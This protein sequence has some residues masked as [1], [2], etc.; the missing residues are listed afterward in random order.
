[1]A[2]VLGLDIGANSIGWALLDESENAGAV[3]AMG[4]RVFPEG[5]AR[6]KSG[7]EI[8]KNEQRRIARGIR[9]QIARRARRKRVLR[10][11]LV[12]AGLYPQHLDEQVT[13]GGLDPYIL[14]EKAVSERLTPHELGRVLIHLN[15]RRGFL[16]NRK[17]DRGKNAKESSETLQQ[18][19]ALAIAIGENTLG[20]HLA[21]IRSHNQHD[22]LRERRTAREMFVREFDRIWEFQT[23]FH[24][25]LLTEELKYGATGKLD[26]PRKPKDL[27]HRKTN[28]L[29]QFVGLHGI[30]FFQR[31]IY[32]PKS[33][34]GIC[35]LEKKEKRC[36]KADRRIQKLRLLQDVN[37]LRIQDARGKERKL[38]SGQRAALVEYLSINGEL[39]FEDL[40]KPLKAVTKTTK[41]PTKIT[42]EGLKHVLALE[43]GDLFNLE[44]GKKPKL[45]GMITDVRLAHKNLFGA[46][47]FERPED[48]KNRIVRSIIDD[49]EHD[50]RHKAL[51]SWGCDAALVEK[52]VK[53]DLG[54]GR[55][56][57]SLVA[58]E[59]L[60]PHLEK[61]L[62]LM[63]NDASDSAL[64]AANYLRD[65]QKVINQ[66][67]NLPAPPDDIRNPLVM[68]ALHE[69]RKLINAIIAEYGKPDA[70]H[71]ELAREVQGGT[72][73]RK[74][75]TERIRE[76]EARRDVA[77]KQIQEAGQAVKRR[78]I[79]AVL[80]W[81]EQQERC[82]YSGRTI[83]LAQ[84]L[85]DAVEVDHILPYSRS[86]D[87]SL[88]N[89]VVC[90]Q[91]ENAAKGNRTPHEWLF[92]QDHQKYEEILQ[93][94]GNLPIE[95]R[96]GKRKK[97]AAENVVIE[98]F[99]ARQLTD[100]AY[101]TR[102][103]HQY[104]RVLGCDVVC[105]KGQC[106]SE[107]RRLWGLND[108]L[109][110]DGIKQKSRDDHRHHA[111]D[112]L[113]IALTNRRRLQQ[114]A[115]YRGIRIPIL[116]KAAEREAFPVPWEHFRSEAQE[117]IDEINVSH[118]PVRR[119]SGA[120]H[121]ET[122][123]GPTSKPERATEAARPHAKGWIENPGVFVSRVKLEALTLSAVGRIR[124]ERVKELVVERLRSRGIAISV[125]NNDDDDAAEAK[126]NIP[127][128]VWDP[129]L[130]MIARGEDPS[131]S[132]AQIIRKV[133]V[134]KTDQTIVP[135][136]EN[137]TKAFVKTGSNHHTCFFKAPGKKP[138][139][140]VIVSVTVS[141][142]EAAA[143]LRRRE[144]IIQRVH[145][146]I[147]SAQFLFS[148]SKGEMVEGTIGGTQGLFRFI[149]IASTSGQM[150]FSLHTDARVSN[151]RKEF[152][153][154]PN[155]LKAT[156]VTVDFLGRIRRAQD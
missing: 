17:S 45:L 95:I 149:K 62:G 93:R 73:Q 18:I 97:I 96:N 84:L 12:Q 7:A 36:E 76:R 71:I 30:L 94:A 32:W 101:I 110:T 142:L 53:L 42:I 35:S 20:Q 114:L 65:D 47:W 56:A 88:M 34:V 48:E 46:A 128:S 145:P 146:T 37:N 4:T 1:M 57:F 24:S 63:G 78:D 134:T 31:A 21:E 136:R 11:A 33:I 122:I 108:V 41:K 138:G 83:S 13:L 22:R 15:Q 27:P 117:K 6:E 61:G 135:I 67:D 85:S 119:V 80:L 141:M 19:S 49:E 54:D 79:D 112:A 100:T 86:L 116:K 109:R 9:R 40:K 125:N 98:D 59:K 123:Y 87:D 133:R 68:Q 118:R 140:P 14:R 105:T 148:I 72:N 26:Y 104:V 99:L 103:V 2:N 90:F 115:H 60:L 82:F 39:L 147:P 106:T 74:E 64:H 51:T 89:K 131:T 111:V 132:T 120:L 52:L 139:K 8:P 25:T 126:G 107:L 23:P 10:A 151:K 58:A 92:E 154:Q 137:G 5:V 55:A 152:S 156:K 129:P 29:L 70:I 91:D 150:I 66:R 127:K 77:A 102:Q 144:E 44:R 28:S 75:Y 50:L 121:E 124:D 130:R 143:R 43:P 155:T 3:M 69:V 113:V 81:K 153:A 16:S 38:L